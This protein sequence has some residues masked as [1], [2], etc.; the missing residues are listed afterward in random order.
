M[1]PCKD[2]LSLL[3]GIKHHGEIRTKMQSLDLSLSLNQPINIWE[4]IYKHLFLQSELVTCSHNQLS[5]LRLA[6]EPGGTKIKYLT[7]SSLYNK[8]L[9]SSLYIMTNSSQLIFY[10][11]YFTI[12]ST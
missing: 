11:K 8:L 7:L 3:E 5:Q 6:S 9:D 4:S 12:E 2:I 1:N 10:A